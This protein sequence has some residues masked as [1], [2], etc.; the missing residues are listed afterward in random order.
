[1]ASCS[2]VSGTLFKCFRIQC[3]SPPEYAQ[4][5]SIA[6]CSYR[7]ILL[8]LDV[9]CVQKSKFQIKS[10]ACL[11]VTGSSRIANLWMGQLGFGVYDL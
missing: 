8:R 7:Y 3:S 5:G 11:H 6:F 4:V 9:A 1:M 10:I 2:N